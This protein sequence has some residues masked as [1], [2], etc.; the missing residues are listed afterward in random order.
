MWDFLPSN[1]CFRPGRGCKDALRE[2]NQWLKRGYTWVVDA[3]LESYFDSVAYLGAADNVSRLL[4]SRLS[5]VNQPIIRS[6]NPLSRPHPARLAC[7]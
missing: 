5:D 3:D 4:P 6:R 7:L 2:V 1:Y